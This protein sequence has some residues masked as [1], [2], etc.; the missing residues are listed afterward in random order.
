MELDNTKPKRRKT[1]TPLHQNRSDDL[2][3]NGRYILIGLIAIILIF[4]VFESNRL[5]TTKNKSPETTEVSETAHL[6]SSLKDAN[7]SISEMNERL[8]SVDRKLTP[9]EDKYAQLITRVEA[10]EGNGRDPNR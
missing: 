7:A 4:V 2:G 3:V 8:S 10:L 1:K 9:L 6:V 5:Q